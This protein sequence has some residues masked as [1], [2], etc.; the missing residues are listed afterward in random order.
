MTSDVSTDVT[1]A[2]AAEK[3]AVLV[4]ALPWLQRFHGA[5]VVIKYG[6]NAMVDDALKAAFAQDMVFL[7]L[8]GLHP[9]VV[10][11]GG[12]QITAMLDRHGFAGAFVFCMDEHDRVPAFCVPNDRTLAH[13]ERSGGR[14]IRGKG[15]GTQS[16]G[17]P[18]LRGGGW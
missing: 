8:A 14:R 12:P 17:W 10:H 16:G 1:R 9:V 18:P 4:E 2:E 13:A 5:T 6:G 7:K 3:A 15:G 11:G